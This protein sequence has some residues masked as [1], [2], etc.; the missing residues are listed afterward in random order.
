MNVALPRTRETINRFDQGLESKIPGFTGLNVALI[1]PEALERK[2]AGAPGSTSLTAFPPLATRRPPRHRYCAPACWDGVQ[3][4]HGSLP[5]VPR[6]RR[7]Q[8]P[9]K[10]PLGSLPPPGP[11]SLMAP[12][13]PRSSVIVVQHGRYRA[14]WG[15]DRQPRFPAPWMT[16]GPKKLIATSTRRPMR[17]LGCQRPPSNRKHAVR[18]SSGP[19]RGSGRSSRPT[20]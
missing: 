15:S 16:V 17:S 7:T 6:H 1:R 3:R 13:G 9:G 18:P 4:G 14:V 11:P 8:E 12:P 2:P 19:A 5:R 10:V 20:K